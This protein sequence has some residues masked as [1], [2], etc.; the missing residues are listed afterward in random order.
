MFIL[1]KE[2]LEKLKKM[3]L[4]RT[5]CNLKI[6]KVGQR[7][8]C[9]Y[10]TTNYNPSSKLMELHEILCKIDLSDESIT[11]FCLYY[12]Q[13]LDDIISTIITSKTENNNFKYEKMPK[14][15][16]AE[17]LDYY[18]KKILR[19]FDE[20]KITET[21]VTIDE[22]TYNV[23]IISILNNMHYIIEDTEKNKNS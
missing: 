20:N 14:K 2:K 7:Y 9:E 19:Y 16:K 15:E 18:L 3:I 17:E 22:N 6:K 5:I 21:E 23:P 4:E 12:D 13:V 8:Y 10:K 11:D 1:D